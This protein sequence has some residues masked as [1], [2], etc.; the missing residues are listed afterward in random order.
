MRFGE[1]KKKTK[2]LHLN[3]TQIQHNFL[4]H[5]S[6]FKQNRI[7]INLCAQLFFS[8]V[9]FR[10]W[11]ASHRRTLAFHKIA[12]Y[13]WRLNVK[14]YTAYSVMPVIFNR[15]T[16]YGCTAHIQHPEYL[17][18]QRW[19]GLAM[20]MCVCVC[21]FIIHLQYVLIDF[22]IKFCFVV[23]RFNLEGCRFVC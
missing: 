1:T 5:L 3:G 12:I 10:A 15:L 13:R 19:I 18:K 2:I 21:V 23:V 6:L 14:R 22:Y 8:L 11:F 16:L 9:A 20:Y 4:V 17:L 7:S